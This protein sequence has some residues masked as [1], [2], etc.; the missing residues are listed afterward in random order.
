MTNPPDFVKVLELEDIICNE[1]WILVSELQDKLA[2]KCSIVYGVYDLELGLVIGSN[3][4]ASKDTHTAFIFGETE[5]V[6]EPCK[7][8][9]ENRYNR[10]LGEHWIC[11]HCGETLKPVAWEIE[12]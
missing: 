10:M 1:K 6:K 2:E 11:Q 4:Q 3:K 5:I 8:E 9:P 12:G 7:H